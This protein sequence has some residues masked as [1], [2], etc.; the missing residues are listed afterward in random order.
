MDRRPDD[1]QGDTDSALSSL[2]HATDQGWVDVWQAEHDSRLAAL[3]SDQRFE[4]WLEEMR[5]RSIEIQA[6]I[7]LG[8]FAAL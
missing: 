1:F 8:Q 5:N 7:N 6:S 4:H 2:T 3:R